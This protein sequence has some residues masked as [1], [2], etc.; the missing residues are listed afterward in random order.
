MT[1]FVYEDCEC[2]DSPIVSYHDYPIITKCP[3]C[4]R[5]YILYEDGTRKER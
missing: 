5:T 2:E 4:K 1:K 3:K